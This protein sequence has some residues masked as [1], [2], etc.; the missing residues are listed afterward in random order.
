M[1]YR[2]ILWDVDDTLLNFKKS[3]EFAFKDSLERF[4][5]PYREE[6]LT[7]YSAIN[8]SFWKKLELGEINK[9]E[10][11]LGRFRQFFQTM[12]EE[13]SSQVSSIDIVAFQKNYQRKLGSVYF[14]R[15]DSLRLCQS[16]KEQGVSQYIVTNGVKWT[17]E[18]KLKLSGFDK[19]VDAIFIS[20]EIGYVKPE[21]PFFDKCFEQIDILERK[22]GNIFERSQTLIVGDSLS[23]DMLGGSNADIATCWYNP[24]RMQNANQ[25][26]RID[27][28]IHHLSEIQ[29]I[30][31]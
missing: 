7:R 20:E 30:I 3:E 15:D 27:Y 17:Q 25:S 22:K 13:G 10:V 26:I 1:K 29:E 16:L 14:Y 21:R 2:Y 28:E 4:G 24:D 6:L 8:K 11:L 18:N 19:V 12:K 31:L 23:S 9:E 5:I